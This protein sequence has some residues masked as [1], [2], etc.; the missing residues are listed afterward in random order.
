MHAMLRLAEELVIPHARPDDRD[1]EFQLLQHP[2]APSPH[3]ALALTLC[4]VGEGDS[5]ALALVAQD[6]L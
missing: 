6:H 5:E 2:Q 3:G 1:D 4:A